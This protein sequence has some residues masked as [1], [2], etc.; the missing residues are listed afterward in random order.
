M[1]SN[2]FVIKHSKL[3][4][5]HLRLHLSTTRVTVLMI[6]LLEVQ[7]SVETEQEKGNNMEPFDQFI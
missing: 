4:V 3:A 6:F 5:E 1:I 2:Q 7:Y